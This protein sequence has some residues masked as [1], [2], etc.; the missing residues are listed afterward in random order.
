MVETRH[1]FLLFRLVHTEVGVSKSSET[2]ILNTYVVVV[3]L[4][5][6]QTTVTFRSRITLSIVDNVPESVASA[7]LTA[8][9][10]DVTLHCVCFGK[11]VPGP[12]KM[13]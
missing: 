13:D 7:P 11:V 6:L 8:V 5:H 4:P 2:R 12:N 10:S 1:K 3:G 9:S